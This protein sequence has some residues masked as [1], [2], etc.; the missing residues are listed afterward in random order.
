MQYFPLFFD[1]KKVKVMV[2]GDGPIALAKLE[3]LCKATKHIKVVSS[4]PISELQEHIEKNQLQ[5]YRQY[6]IELL[7]EVQLLV[8]A[9]HDKVLSKR[10]QEHAKIRNIPTNV[11][12]DRTNCDFIFPALVDRGDLVVAVTTSGVAPVVASWLRTVFEKQLPRQWEVIMNSLKA[13]RLEISNAF[14][15]LRLKRKF[16]YTLIEKFLPQWLNSKHDK[17]LI[18]TE[19]SEALAQVTKDTYTKPRG[20]VY[21]VGGGP[22]DPELLTLKAQRLLQQADVVFYD[23]LLGDTVLEM[24]RRDAKKVYVGKQAANHHTKQP[25]INMMLVEEAQKGN[26]VI[27]LKGGDPFI[28]GRGGEE[29]EYLEKNHIDYAI[30]PG[31]SAFNGI[32]AELRLPLTQRHIANKLMLTSVYNANFETVDWLTLAAK[33]QTLVLYMG[34]AKLIRTCKKLDQYGLSKNTPL[35]LV[36]KGTWR[37]QQ[38]VYTTIGSITTEK[39]ESLT[40]PVLT[41][42]GPAVGQSKGYQANLN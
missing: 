24:V 3:L 13:K 39:I 30:V 22:G 18:Y 42:I 15:D 20:K 1:L 27:R 29:I 10:I 25:E 23:R 6:D 5:H 12:D 31:I 34:L 9:S 16:Y 33:E 8:L 40:S 2:V 19:I 41:I 37:E 21:L 28:F 7:Q 36:E 11:V 14:K 4:N 38:V 35:V 17:Q 32:A 26:M